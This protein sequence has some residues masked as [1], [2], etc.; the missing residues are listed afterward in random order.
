MRMTSFFTMRYL[1]VLQ[2]ASSV[3]A[4]FLWFSNVSYGESSI[5]QFADV[6]GR[7]TGHAFANKYSVSLEID[8]AG[9]FKARALLTSETGEAKLENGRLVIPLLE[10]HGALQLV[11]DGETLRGPGFVAGRSGPVT[12]VRADRTVKNE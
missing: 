1:K 7:W 5:T 11:L 3:A 8:A 4:A 2:R 9:K 6:A 12:L 10:H